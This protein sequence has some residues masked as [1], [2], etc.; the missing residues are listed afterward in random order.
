M[1]CRPR[2]IRSVHNSNVQKN[3]WLKEML[4]KSSHIKYQGLL[5]MQRHVF[6]RL[7]NRLKAKNYLKSYTI[8]KCI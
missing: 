4:N 1:Q 3:A 7:C 5:R 8:C 6:F 2:E